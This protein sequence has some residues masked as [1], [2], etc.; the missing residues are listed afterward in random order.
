MQFKGHAKLPTVAFLI[1][2]NKSRMRGFTH[3]GVWANEDLFYFFRLQCLT[4]LLELK[5]CDNA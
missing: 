5:P 2:F 4:A 1:P 3:K